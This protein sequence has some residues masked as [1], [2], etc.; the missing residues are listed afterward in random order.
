[1]KGEKEIKQVAGAVA[2]AVEK[3][4]VAEAVAGAV[5]KK[6]GKSHQ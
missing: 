2:G 1:V 4:Q 6:I 3:R 5:E